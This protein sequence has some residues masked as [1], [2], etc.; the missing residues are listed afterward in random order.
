MI[1]I[2]FFFVISSLKLMKRYLEFVHEGLSHDV[3]EQGGRVDLQVLALAEALLLF[4]ARLLVR[5]RLRLIVIFIVVVIGT[6]SRDVQS[7]APRG[8]QRG[9]NLVDGMMQEDGSQ[10]GLGLFE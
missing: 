1:Y 6:V 8:R 5:T 2:S 9:S 10:R 4:L 7:F 3:A